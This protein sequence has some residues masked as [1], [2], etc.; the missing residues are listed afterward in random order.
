MAP[1]HSSDPDGASQHCLAPEPQRQ[2]RFPSSAVAFV[3]APPVPSGAVGLLILGCPEEYSQGL[4][5]SIGNNTVSA[6]KHYGTW[7]MPVGEA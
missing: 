1:L 4:R 5:G 2:V 3:I 6:S 7:Q